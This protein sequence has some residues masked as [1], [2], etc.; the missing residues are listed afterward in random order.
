MRNTGAGSRPK[1]SLKSA[2]GALLLGVLCGLLAAP[3]AHAGSC[4]PPAPR[5]SPAALQALA[6]QAPDRGFLWRISKGGHSSWLYGTVHAGSP[7]L[8]LPGP[9]VRAALAASR[10]L[11]LELDL[12]DPAVM[13]ALMQ[14]LAPGDAR[15]PPEAEARVQQALARECL[16]PT[17]TERLHPMM[18]PATLEVANAQRVG[19]YTEYGVDMVLA[20]VAIALDLRRSSLETVAE[21]ANA[22]I[23][24][25]RRRVDAAELLQALDEAE[26]PDAP[27]LLQRMVKAWAEGDAATLS[28]YL[29][30]CDC[31]RT[32]EDHTR[33]Q[34]LLADRN[35][36]LAERIDRLHAQ[37]QP[38]F[39]AVGSL[40]L[41]APAALPALMAAR[42]YTVERVS[43]S[44]PPASPRAT[45]T[46]T[47]LESPAADSN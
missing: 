11:A 40:H 33:W 35:P 42:G 32:P 36:V 5:P 29:Q 41:F 18:L 23:G 20:G 16:P 30:W 46:G 45:Q 22:L 2:L 3:A 28:T 8:S 14:A 34:R 24:P 25:D 37:G 27:A 4:P 10:V 17:I 21:Q 9:Q 43:F 1:T 26:R 13:R 47:A 19:L 7:E 39:A 31:L 6:R 44:A 38:V 15:V 12:A